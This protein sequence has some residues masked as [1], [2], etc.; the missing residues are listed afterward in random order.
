MKVAQIA[1]APSLPIIG[2]RLPNSPQAKPKNASVAT[3]TTISLGNLPPRQSMAI[4]APAS[5]NNGNG[6]IPTFQVS[7]MCHHLSFNDGF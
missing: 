2:R 4:N 7:I 5:K 6:I 1:A 3:I